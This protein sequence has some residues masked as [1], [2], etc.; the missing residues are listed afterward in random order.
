MDIFVEKGTRDFGYNE[1]TES[2][3]EN[4]KNNGTEKDFYDTMR[5]KT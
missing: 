1:I 5:K 3:L 4:N 2:L